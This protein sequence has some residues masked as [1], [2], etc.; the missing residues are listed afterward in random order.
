MLTSFLWILV[1]VQLLESAKG[2]TPRGVFLS[3]QNSYF[4]SWFQ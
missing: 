3:S 1:Y 2:D 4:S